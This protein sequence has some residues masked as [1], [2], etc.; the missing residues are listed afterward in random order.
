LVSLY[1][2]QSDGTSAANSLTVFLEPALVL[3]WSSKALMVPT[4]LGAC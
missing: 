4:L 3:G 2:C 1:S